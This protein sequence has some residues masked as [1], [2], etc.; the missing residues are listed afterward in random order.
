M[1]GVYIGEEVEQLQPEEEV[2]KLRIEHCGLGTEESS[3]IKDIE[4]RLPGGLPSSPAL[5]NFKKK[6]LTIKS[7]P[8]LIRSPRKH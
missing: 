7:W 1:S 6:L 4:D 8:E 2:L 3:N 5:K